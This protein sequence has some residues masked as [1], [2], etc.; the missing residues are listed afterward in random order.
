[1]IGTPPLALSAADVVV[2]CPQSF[3][4]AVGDWVQ[5][6]RDEGLSVQIIESDRDADKLTAAIRGTARQ[7]TDFVVLIGD[8][9]TMGQPCDPLKQ[10]PV[11]YRPT[12]VSAEYGSTPLLSSD[13]CYGDFDG[14]G[15]P[16]AAVGRLPV[17]TPA[18]LTRLIERI[19][20]HESSRNFGSWRNRVN[21]VGGVGGFSPLIDNTIETA[22]RTIV[23]S[24]LPGETC[25]CVAHASPGHKF[26]P[27]QPFTTA[28]LDRYQQGCRF[29]VYAGHGLITELDRV[30]PRTGK[31]ILDCESVNRLDR[32][33]GNSPVALLLACYSGAVDGPR[34]SLA[35]EMI[36]C[37]GGPIAVLGGSRVTM[38]YGNTITAVGMIK[39]VYADRAPRLGT[40]WLR[41]VQ[42]MYQEQIEDSSTTRVMIEA[43]AGMFSPKGTK[44][45]D[46]RREHLLLYNL[47]GD[48]TLKLHHPRTAEVAVASGHAPDEAIR[49]DV[50][51]PIDGQ[52][53]ISLDRPLGSG[54]GDDP[55]DLTVASI[56]T[57]TVADKSVEHSFQLPSEL[58]G[59]ITVRVFVEGE[60][61]WATGS[62]RTIIR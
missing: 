25:V 9:P 15:N 3:R 48:P 42:Q 55:H 37:D 16:D 17:D 20:A 49:V 1:M 51:S 23:T 45:L 30:P 2:V 43:L 52:L 34:D 29:W 13:G 8:A 58:R 56:T 19:I 54:T 4:A 53:T 57:A 18:E 21:L 47:I 11:H 39:A 7:R 33:L 26:F 62:A 41:T 60:S 61:A 38:P 44:L 35:E 12:T 22:T 32:P 24:A 40:A 59:P 5:H 28:V 31:P 6:R 36:R 10:V 27:R 14:D 46:E 50:T